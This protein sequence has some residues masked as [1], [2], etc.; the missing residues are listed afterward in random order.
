MLDVRP[1]PAPLPKAPR[2]TAPFF[3]SI[4]TFQHP[5][6]EKKATVYVKEGDFFRE[7]GGLTEAWGKHWTGIKATS[8]ADARLKAHASVGTA[9]PHWHLQHDAE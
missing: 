8:L 6:Q 5:F 9:C 3:V 4:S 7:Q 1:K 2:K